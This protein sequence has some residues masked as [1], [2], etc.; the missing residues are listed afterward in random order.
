MRSMSIFALAASLLGLS[1]ALPVKASA[2]CVIANNAADL[3]TQLTNAQGS[4]T[5]TVVQVPRGTYNLGGSQLSFN[6]QAAGQG[7]FDITGG[8]NSDCS[9]HLNNP[10]LTIIDG[11]SLGSG[12]LGLQSTAGI[13]VRFLTIQGAAGPPGLDVESVNGGII[14]DY[15]I[16]RNNAAD[17]NAGI[18]VKIT[19][20]T[21][22]S[23]IHVDGNLIAGNT[24]ANQD[25]AGSVENDGTGSTYVTNNTIANNIS[26]VFAG[27]GGLAVSGNT[28][29]G[30]T[31]VSNNI[32]WG[33]S[34]FD[35]YLNGPSL[36]TDPVLVD[37]DYQYSNCCLGPGST[38]NQNLDPQFSS[39]GDFHLSLGSPLLA[40]GL[41]NPKPAG[42]LPSVDIVGNPRTYDLT[43]VAAT[44]KV[45][46]GA[47]ERGDEIF[48]DGLNN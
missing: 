48:K 47:Y 6:S 21:A 41:C 4:T 25:G 14:I 35:V 5:T 29:A 12:V 39:S 33:N 36:Q 31:N 44:C 16:I 20:T 7:Q 43:Y 15:N 3:Q 2:V 30:S 37:N 13:S 45:D 32:L 18:L 22:A 38:G 26:Q 9:T 8:Y 24:A 1:A 46:M 23:A 28:I 11:Q 27:I 40:Q 42:G 34:N 17:S 19:G 10:A